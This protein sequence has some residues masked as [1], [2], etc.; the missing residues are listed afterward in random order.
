MVRAVTL[1]VLLVL[2]GVA[3]WFTC[4]HLA[5]VTAVQS[6]RGY[7]P[8]FILGVLFGPLVLLIALAA[9]PAAKTAR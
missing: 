8:W 6:G 7:V 2:A 4:A 5:G 9:A 1:L 3:L